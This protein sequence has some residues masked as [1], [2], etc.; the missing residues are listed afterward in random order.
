[1]RNFDADERAVDEF[2]ASAAADDRLVPE[3]WLSVSSEGSGEELVIKFV[4]RPE[5]TF[6]GRCGT[7]YSAR[8]EESETEVRVSIVSVTSLAGGASSVAECGSAV[9][10]RTVRVRLST[11]LGSR[12]VI[13]EA[14]GRS[15]EV[16]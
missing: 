14:T 6:D 16:G 12:E 13:N 1:M 9:E 8:A 5:R 7:A 11:P 3:T 4:G 15:E 10:D 2:M